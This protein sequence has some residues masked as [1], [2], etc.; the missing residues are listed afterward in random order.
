MPAA[1]WDAVCAGRRSYGIRN[2]AILRAVK[3]IGVPDLA[4]R[5]GF[6]TVFRSLL[7]PPSYF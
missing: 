5:I 7:R 4:I 2:H 1:A 6:Y 3:T